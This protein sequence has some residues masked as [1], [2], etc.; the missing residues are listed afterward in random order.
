[1]QW[2]ETHGADSLSKEAVT[3][4]FIDNDYVV[5][6]TYFDGILSEEK[7]VNALYAKMKDMLEANY[8]N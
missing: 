4:Q 8:K 5:S 3:N 7:R 6:A 1:M 2:F